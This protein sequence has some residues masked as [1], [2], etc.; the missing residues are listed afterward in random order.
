MRICWRQLHLLENLTM[1]GAAS[2]Q[3]AS[4]QPVILLNKGEGELFAGRPNKVQI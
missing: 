3:V 2:F 4:E 1:P